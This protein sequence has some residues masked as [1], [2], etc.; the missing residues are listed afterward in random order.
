MFMPTVAT[1][2]LQAFKAAFFKALA[3]PVRIRIL[4]VLVRGERSVQELQDA[5]ELDQPVVSQQLGVLRTSNI[6]LGKKQGVSVRY[7][8]RDPLVADLLVIARR[9]FNNHLVSTQ[10]L[11]RQLKHEHRRR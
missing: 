11:L 7:G 3:H 10:D 1:E 8:V 2:E 5:L 9:I 4:E 6:V